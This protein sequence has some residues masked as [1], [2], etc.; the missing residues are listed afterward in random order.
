MNPDG[1]WLPLA[2]DVLTLRGDRICDVT[3]FRDTDL[4]GIFGL[5]HKLD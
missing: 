3:A 4:F 1:E 5:P 2:I